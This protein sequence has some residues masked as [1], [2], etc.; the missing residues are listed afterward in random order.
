M[1]GG[2]EVGVCSG[3]MCACDDL[4]VILHQSNHGAPRPFGKNG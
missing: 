2:G 1:G 4:V 3:G